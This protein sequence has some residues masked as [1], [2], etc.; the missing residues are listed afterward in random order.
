M[1]R[2]SGFLIG[3]YEIG[4]RI[5]SGGFAEVRLARHVITGLSVALKIFPK[6]LLN[7]EESERMFHYE[8][9]MHKKLDHPLIVGLYDV[10]EDENNF[11]IALEYVGGGSLLKLINESHGIAEP[12]AARIFSQIIS[13]MEYLH[14]EKGVVHRDLKPD[15]I[16]LDDSGN[17][18]LIDFGLS[19]DFSDDGLFST[20]CGSSYYIAPE[21]LDGKAYGPEV[22]V[23]S[24]GVVLYAMITGE[25][26]FYHDNENMVLQQILRQEPDYDFEATSTCINL[27]RRIFK[28]N[29]QERI[30]ISG[31]KSHRFVASSVYLSRQIRLQL[32]N[33][34]ESDVPKLDGDTILDMKDMGI[35]TL[36]MAN[37]I[38][39]GV[40]NSVTATYRMLRK[41]RINNQWALMARRIVPGIMR[42]KTSIVRSTIMHPI[43][44]RDQALLPRKGQRPRVPAPS[45]DAARVLVRARLASRCGCRSLGLWGNELKL[46]D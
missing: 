34:S 33:G 36:S 3:D 5:G 11:Y 7:S 38:E 20:Q 17:I 28:K 41:E 46:T 8:V 42:H 39:N 14:E 13:V 40:Y 37:L 26:P 18:R 43:V 21:I 25:L 32:T 29:P 9:S 1:R 35:D 31:I 27:L 4:K 16:L 30:T 44:V 15:N 24:C 45:P 22:D 12:E 19:R 10:T 2:A 23:W 6:N